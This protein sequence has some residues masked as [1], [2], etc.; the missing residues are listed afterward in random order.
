M[1]LSDYPKK[2]KDWFDE[3]NQEIQKMLVEKYQHTKL[4]WLKLPAHRRRR[5]SV[6]HVALFNESFEIF[7]M[8]GGKNSALRRHRNLESRLIR[9]KNLSQQTPKSATRCCPSHDQNEKTRVHHCCTDRSSLGLLKQRIEY[10]LL[11]LTFQSLHGLFASYLTN[12]LIR[13]DQTRALRSADAHL[14]E[15]PRCRLPIQGENAFSSAAHA[16]RTIY[17]LRATDCLS[18]F[19][20]QLKTLLF[21]R[22]FSL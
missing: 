13:Y 1:K 22:A 6:L 11:L 19:K 5:P 7:R 8:N 21:K 9:Q 17:R 16:S 12:L 18:S 2:N 20:K 10:K 4:T 15:V 14:L 3:D